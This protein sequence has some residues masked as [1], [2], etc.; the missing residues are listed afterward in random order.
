MAETISDLLGGVCGLLLAGEIDFKTKKCKFFYLI[1]IRLQGRVYLGSNI[2]TYN[3]I[4]LE[5]RR[6]ITLA[7]R[8]YFRLRKQLSKK[9]S[10]EERKFAYISLLYCRLLY[11]GETWTIASPDEHALGVY[12]R[13]I[14][15]KIYGPLCDG[16]EW[17][18]RWNQELY[19][20]IYDVID[21]VQHIKI[22]RLRWLGH[23]ARMDSSNPV[24]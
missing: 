21:V 2:N 13:K 12:E 7:N 10:L 4:S 14:L 24:R 18:I 23:V 17:H 1:Y 19:D 3:D 22:Q 20:I 11:G 9:V 5:I 15:P 8:Y 16:G 6:S